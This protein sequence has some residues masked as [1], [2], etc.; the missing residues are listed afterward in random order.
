[1]AESLKPLEWYERR[2]EWLTRELLKIEIMAT[3][4]KYAKIG[5]EKQLARIRE[6]IHRL[7]LANYYKAKPVKS[8]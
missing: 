2:S 4:K 1:M 3:P 5:A 8:G 7:D 6:R